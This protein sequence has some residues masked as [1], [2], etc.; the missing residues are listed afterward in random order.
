MTGLTSWGQVRPRGVR[1]QVAEVRVCLSLLSMTA[2]GIT[3]NCSRA[4]AKFQKVR[5]GLSLES[6]HLY[7]RGSAPES[8][9]LRP[10][11]FQFLCSLLGQKQPE[12]HHLWKLPASLPGA[13]TPTQLLLLGGGSIDDSHWGGAG[14][15]AAFQEGTSVLAFLMS[16][17][18]GNGAFP[19]CSPSGL[20]FLH[21]VQA[22]V[23]TLW[24]EGLSP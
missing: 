19:R 18:P 16:D 23:A 1:E 20:P 13:G 22:P 17:H 8:D 15:G 11:G 24:E 2:T 5:K 14:A 10:T 3:D 6:Q 12:K 9:P 7:K 4:I 21:K